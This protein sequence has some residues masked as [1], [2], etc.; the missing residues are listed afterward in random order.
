[1][2]FLY[3]TRLFPEREY[4][5]K[6]AL[7][8]EV[9]Y[10][11]LLQERRRGLHA[12][13][14]E[15]FEALTG[16]RVAKVASGRSPEQVELLAHHALRGAVWDKAMT[17][18]RQ[19]GARAF[20]RAAFRQA[21][22][23]FEQALEA[24][25][26]LPDT[27]DT[28]ELALDLRL[29]LALLWSMLG[30]YER[31]LILLRE[32]EALA[33]ARNDQARLARVLA[34]LA[35]LL[36][37]RPAFAGALA[38]GQQALAL[39]TA[40]GDL[41]LQMEV[42]FRLGN[43]YSAIGD[44][45]RAAELLRRNVEA[46]DPGTG[47]SDLP[48]RVPSQACLPAVLSQLGQFTEGRR[49][50]EEALCH[51]TVEGRQSPILIH[52]HLGRLYL[53][54]GDLAAAIRLLDQGLALCRAA[55]DRDTGRAAAANLG[56]AYALAGRLAEGRA[57]LEEALGEGLRMG[58]LQAQSLYVAWLSAVCL[59]E[60]RVDEAMQH[61]G[62]ALALARQYGERG[63]EAVALCQ[64]GA[65]HAQTD[66]PE[67]AQSEVRYRGALALAQALGMRPLQ[68]HCHHGLGTLYAR[69]G[70]REQARAELSTAIESYR[71]MEM[72]FWLP[73]AEA[74]LVRAG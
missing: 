45:G 61:A 36:R 57:L 32:A 39:A 64:L 47:R 7:T 58:V 68:A 24:L 40:L 1:V 63:C 22:T 56:Y 70:Q 72:T 43:L 42:S 51:A 19:A 34:L 10:G 69:S 66:P 8:H 35:A 67:V 52:H 50:G 30:E 25:G 4:T 18:S 59:L 60:G 16:D 17:Y 65:V 3:E 62:Q 54:Q 37:R 38:A 6:H 15:A 28:R 53:A 9:A 55:D 73:Q 74:A 44:Y 20:E 46:R 23:Y 29:R 11:S 14:V 33:R 49:H 31:M 12:H 2:E 48:Y 5:F 13:I 26:R 41:G 71:T 27:P 21:A